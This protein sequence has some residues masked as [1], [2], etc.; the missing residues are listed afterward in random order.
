MGQ[1]TQRDGQVV[2]DR[3]I[4]D[5]VRR[6]ARQL[7]GKAGFTRSDR[8]DIEQELYLKL[9]KAARLFD[10]TQAHWHSFATAVIERH[11]A[12]LL[13][14][15]RAEKRDSRCVCSLDVVVTEDEEGPVQLGETIGQDEYDNRRGRWPRQ[16]QELFELAQDVADVIAGLPAELRELAEALKTESL[17]EIARR[18]G[19]ARSTLNARVQQLRERLERAGLKNYL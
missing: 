17:S 6:K 16:E 11:T 18:T 4:R 7:V 8:E 19:V 5:L 2:I 1:H 13:R 14:D 12:S 3:F 15:K 10:P 9:L